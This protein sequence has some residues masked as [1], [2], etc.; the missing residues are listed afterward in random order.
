MRRDVGGTQARGGIASIGALV[1]L[2]LVLGPAPWADAAPLQ[3]IHKIQHV[4]MIMQENRS[5]DS[6]FGTFPGA[7]RIPAGVCVP[8]PV[9][10]GCVEPFHES[11]DRYP[12][13]P[14]GTGS[15]VADID[16]GKMDGFVAQAEGKF[17]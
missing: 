3:G 2:V 8:D 5:F 17:G 4:V 12:G 14:H 13:G 1:V 11:S 9:N 16:G 7:S 10:G 15:A 6:Y